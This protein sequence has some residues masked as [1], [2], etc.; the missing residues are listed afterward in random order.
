MAE[1][2]AG[3]VS[4]AGDAGRG[5]D[6]DYLDDL[7]AKLTAHL[8]IGVVIMGLAVARVLW[9]RIGGLPPWASTLSAAERRLAGLTEKALLGLL[10]VMPATGI[11]LV[12]GGEDDLLPLHIG[13]HIA[14][15]VVIALHV[16]M[17][18]KHQL[19]DRDRLIGRMTW[20]RSTTDGSGTN[21]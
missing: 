11:V 3:A 6:F 1:G 18:L 4:P 10:F 17:V 20:G 15:F 7:N 14:F 19:I 16:G 13:A 12:L 8:V 5:G 9:R 2:A 21:G